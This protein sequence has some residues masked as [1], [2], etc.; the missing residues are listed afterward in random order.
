MPALVINPL[1]G[2]TLK[3]L[4]ALAEFRSDFTV[5]VSGIVSPIVFN[6]VLIEATYPSRTLQSLLQ[7]QHQF[8]TTATWCPSMIIRIYSLSAK[9]RHRKPF[10]S[11]LMQIRLPR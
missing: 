11:Q 2:Q 6:A 7:S 9:R 3:R 4:F 1:I 10:Q 5:S 8:P